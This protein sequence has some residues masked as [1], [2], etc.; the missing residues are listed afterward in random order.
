[1]N[2]EELVYSILREVDFT[3]RF[4]RM[5]TRPTLFTDKT[6]TDGTPVSLENVKDYLKNLDLND[7]FI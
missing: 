5:V 1:M 7:P 3:G 6:L 2:Y 4:K